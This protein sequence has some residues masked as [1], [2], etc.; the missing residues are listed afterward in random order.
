MGASI[1]RSSVIISEEMGRGYV[2][3]GYAEDGTGHGFLCIG[4]ANDDN[5]NI[6]WVDIYKREGKG[7]PFNETPIDRLDPTYK[8][9]LVDA[10]ISGDGRDLIVTVTTHAPQEAP[11]PTAIEELVVEGVCTPQAPPAPPVPGEDPTPCVPP[12]NLPYFKPN[13]TVT[14]AQVAKMI[15]LATGK[16]A[17]NPGKQSFQDVPVGSTFHQ[18]VEALAEDGVVG[19]YACTPE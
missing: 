19:G 5:P 12:G 17:N 1:K 9:D 6:R 3:H 13:K 11:R 2:S 16:T 7:Q 4:K 15:A 10:D 14:R 8:L 18:Y